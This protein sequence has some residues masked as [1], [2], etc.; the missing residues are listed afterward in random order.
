MTCREFVQL[1]LEHVDGELPSSVDE[2]IREHAGDCPPCGDYLDGYRA[3]PELS[4][5]CCEES[6]GEIPD[7]LVSS[8]LQAVRSRV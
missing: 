7:E 1:L 5:R 8:I 2:L 4:R 6:T 3:V